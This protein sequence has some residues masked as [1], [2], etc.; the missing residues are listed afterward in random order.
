M[1]AAPKQEAAT[2][3]SAAGDAK[4]G[5]KRGDYVSTDHMYD[6]PGLAAAYE[7]SV[8]AADPKKSLGLT[9]AE[10][11]MRLARDGPNVLTPPKKVPEWIKFLR[12]LVNPFLLLL[13]AAGGL[14]IATYIADNSIIIN[15]WLG[16]ILN[17]VAFTTATMTWWQVCHAWPWCRKRGAPRPGCV[18]RGSRLC[19]CWRRRTFSARSRARCCVLR[20]R[21]RISIASVVCLV[22]VA[23][24]CPAVVRATVDRRNIYSSSFVFPV[25]TVRRLAVAVV[26]AA[27][28][29]CCR[30]CVH[31]YKINAACAFV[32][33]CHASSCVCAHIDEPCTGDVAGSPNQQDHCG[34]QEPHPQCGACHP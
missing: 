10:A 21:R 2:A 29:Y 31:R 13:Q 11:A 14:S 15:L 5:P 26:F 7:T 32:A 27:A 24:A 12:Q 16:L 23:T 8:N 4:P 6:L 1:S 9:V 3:P 19:A 20:R 34:V 22:C 25:G 33:R 17:G 30:T 18:L 28:S